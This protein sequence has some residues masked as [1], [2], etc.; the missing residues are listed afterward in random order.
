[1]LL[2]KALVNIALLGTDRHQLGSDHQA[3]LEELGI[4]VNQDAA[5]VV[6][7]G[8]GVFHMMRKAGRQLDQYTGAFPSTDD[9]QEETIC[10]PKASQMLHEIR[11]GKQ[12]PALVEFIDL[13]VQHQQILPPEML[14]ELIEQAQKSPESWEQLR[15]CIG[16][17]G[18]WLIDQNPAWK[19]L[20]APQHPALWETSGRAERLG[21]FRHLRETDPP[22]SIELL[23]ATWA[24]ESLTSKKAFLKCLEFKVCPVDEAFLET[25]LDEGQKSIRPIAA[26]LLAQL[27]GAAL[28]QRMQERLHQ[29][30]KAQDGQLEFNLP[31]QVEDQM[32]RDGINPSLQWYR[33]GLKASRLVQLVAMVNPCFWQEKLEMEVK[34]CLEVLLRN[35]YAELLLQ[36]IC[37]A[38][39]LHRNEDWLKVLAQSWLAEEQENLWNNSAADLLLEVLPNALFNQLASHHLQQLATIPEENTPLDRLLKLEQQNWS[40]ALTATFIPLFRDWLASDEATAWGGWNLR[41]IIKI[42]AYRIPPYLFPAVNAAWPREH[43]VWGA[44]EKDIEAFLSTLKFREQMREEFE[45]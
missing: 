37:Q 1:M 38:T 9:Y 3:A 8:G 14:P 34:E 4:D 40:K 12:A 39:A 19:H 18:L 17:R 22:K 44:W 11:Y 15:P 2:W 23:Q 21:L 16:Q 20:N 45:G 33:G 28:Q 35:D 27:P 6:L 43:P 29:L 36:A 41:Q 5:E 7:E 42:A 10:S 13:L 24:T 26:R 25:C 30:C 32:I 31:D